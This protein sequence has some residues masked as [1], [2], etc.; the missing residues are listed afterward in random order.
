MDSRDIGI[1]IVEI[2]RIRRAL[3][4]FPRFAERIFSPAERAEAEKRVAPSAYFA[5]RFAA[6]EAVAKALGR[7]FAWQEVEVL[8]ER[9]GRPRA[10]LH[11]RAQQVSEG[12]QV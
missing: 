7:S 10:H 4:R 6:K 3:E 11:G 9:G 12:L 2:A 5:G 8:G 1:D